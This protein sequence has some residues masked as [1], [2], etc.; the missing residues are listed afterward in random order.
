MSEHPRPP[1]PG[2]ARPYPW[3]RTTAL[4]L[5]LVVFAA[6]MHASPAARDGV[7]VTIFQPIG[8]AIGALV[9]LF[10]GPGDEAGSARS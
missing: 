3:L 7:Y 6:V 2:P 10:D 8:A 4:A 9:D 5:V 1:T